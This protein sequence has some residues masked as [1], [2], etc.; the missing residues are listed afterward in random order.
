[1]LNSHSFRAVF[2]WLI[3]YYVLLC[4][5]LLFLLPTLSTL[6]A[7][8]HTCPLSPWSVPGVPAGLS[9]AQGGVCGRA[10]GSCLCLAQRELHSQ[11]PDTTAGWAGLWSLA[12][13]DFE[14]PAVERELWHLCFRSVMP[15]GLDEHQDVC[16]RPSDV[17]GGVGSQHSVE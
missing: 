6:Q 16:P 10:V 4:E 1:M 9:C 8:S 11:C 14:S 7:V 12:L 5:C 3:L 17:G 2:I 15:S 13:Q